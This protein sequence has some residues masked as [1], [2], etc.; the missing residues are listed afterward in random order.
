[1]QL[2]KKDG[3]FAHIIL[4]NPEKHNAFNEQLI[5]DITQTLKDIEQDDSIR[6]V[7]LSAEGAS[8]SAGADLNWMKKMAAYS[9]EENFADAMKLAHLMETLNN[10]NKPTIALV[11][12]NA[13]GGALGLIACCDIALSV[14]TALFCFSEV[15]LGLIPAV[16][17]PYTI[18]AIGERMARRYFLTAERF[19]AQE[20]LNMSL[21]HIIS[22]N[23]L[24]DG[25]ALAEKIA[26][27]GPQALRHIKQLT[28][29][30][31]QS[32]MNEDLMQTTA[33][34]IAEARVSQEGQEGLGAFL[35][36]RTPNWI[37]NS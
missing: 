33:K 19:S 17:S 9:A 26:Q 4:N 7:L 3:P 13:F 21:I 28:R 34:A 37:P 5:E 8:F 22:E 23:L 31:A 36:K 15:K 14:P 29:K 18:T 35:E 32:F 6:V 16:I 1:M 11:Q 30:V 20:A 2:F 25:L 27:N 12:G 24:S 10:L